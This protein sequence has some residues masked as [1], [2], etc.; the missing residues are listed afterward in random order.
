MKKLTE[1]I[2]VLDCAMYI[3]GLCK[4]YDY[5]FDR[6]MYRLF[7]Q[8]VKRGRGDDRLLFTI[9]DNG[10]VNLDYLE[11]DTE[12]NVE[13]LNA[14]KYCLTSTREFL[15]TCGWDV[16]ECLEQWDNYTKEEGEDN[17]GEKEN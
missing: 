1:K 8:Y 4:D 5:P 10:M 13:A 12:L 6:Y 9:Q 17:E 2:S 14:V 11:T 15:E 3:D 16:D 7:N